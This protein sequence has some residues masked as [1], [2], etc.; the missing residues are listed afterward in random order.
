M[1]GSKKVINFFI[2]F[3][4]SLLFL[5]VTGRFI[6]FIS[7]YTN[8]NI[9]FNVIIPIYY[10]ICL[11]VFALSMNFVRNAQTDKLLKNNT[12]YM[13]VN[14]A[15]FSL[16]NKILYYVII[17]LIYCLPFLR[18]ESIKN[19][20]ITR[21]ISL[22]LVLLVF[23]LMLRYSSKTIKITFLKNGIVV[24]GFDLRLDA[25]M[26]TGTIMYNNSGYYSYNDIENYFVFP[27]KI[28]LYL[29]HNQGKLSFHSNTEMGKRFT[30]LMIQQH[31]EMKKFD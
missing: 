7:N 22:V 31:I 18:G 19:F 15:G 3:T 1:S 20:N 12:T 26:K 8:D 2:S 9:L 17:A 4:I 11:L 21:V 14:T 6:Y 27:D 28:E 23:E 10:T 24:N 16:V 13:E 29:I 25:P 30:G 5:S